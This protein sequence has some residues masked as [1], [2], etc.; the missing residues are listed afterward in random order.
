MFGEFLIYIFFL[1]EYVWKS[2]LFCRE[3]DGE[4]MRFCNLPVLSHIFEEQIKIGSDFRENMYGNP[5]I[6]KGNGRQ[7]QEVL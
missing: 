7:G 2:L 1:R 6:L 3:I 4:V 5:F